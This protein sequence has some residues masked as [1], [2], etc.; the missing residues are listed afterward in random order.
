MQESMNQLKEK[1]KKLEKRIQSQAD[2]IKTASQK[3]EMVRM[4]KWEVEGLQN[5][6]RSLEKS[7][8]SK[9]PNKRKDQM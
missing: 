5:K 3:R 6:V 8:R 2:K 7:L 9:T 4:D 1:K